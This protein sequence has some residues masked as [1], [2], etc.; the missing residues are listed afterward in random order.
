M[1]E[2]KVLDPVHLLL[3]PLPLTS[4]GVI[5]RQWQI[6]QTASRANS[7]TGHKYSLW[8][9]SEAN[10]LDKMIGM[11]GNKKLSSAQNATSCPQFLTPLRL[12]QIP[13][14]KWCKGTK[15][16]CIY[17]NWLWKQFKRLE[18]DVRELKADV[19]LLQK[20][21]EFQSSSSQQ[22]CHFDNENNNCRIIWRV[23]KLNSFF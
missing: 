13:K 20:L 23:W 17:L 16:E 19:C 3:L 5:P 1:S 10:I 8:H 21:G 2:T 9:I 18:L 14:L 11:T 4:P 22:H 15:I 7:I 6:G 12:L